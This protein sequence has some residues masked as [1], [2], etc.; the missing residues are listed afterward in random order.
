MTD[1]NKP[2][3]TAAWIARSTAAEVLARRPEINGILSDSSR[4]T[5]ATALAGAIVT[6]TV[7]TRGAD[8]AV[9]RSPDG[10]VNHFLPR[11]AVVNGAWNPNVDIDNSGVIRNGE[12]QSLVIAYARVISSGAALNGVT[13]D[14][15][16]QRSND[17]YKQIVQA[18]PPCEREKI[19]R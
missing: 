4:L 19:C 11:D 18:L 1:E 5:E 14:T 9:I 17:I 3:I 2:P 8:G 15:I 13:V 7:S 16:E 12:L 10:L 6:H